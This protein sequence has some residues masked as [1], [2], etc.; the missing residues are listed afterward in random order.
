M[1]KCKARWL[2]VTATAPLA[3]LT[4]GILSAAD[5]PNLSIV[6]TGQSLLQSDIRAD[7]PTA[8]ET[9]R[10][11]LNGDVVFRSTPISQ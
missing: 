1:T 7:T 8:T 11:L 10:P 5:R 2:A 6:L 3:F 9:I 4:A